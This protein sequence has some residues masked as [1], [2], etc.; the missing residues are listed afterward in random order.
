MPPTIRRHPARPPDELDAVGRLTV[1]A[2]VGAWRHPARRAVP[3]VPRRRR[4]PRR[5]GRA[6]GGGRRGRG[7]VGTVTF[8]EPGSALCEIARDGEAEIRSLAVAPAASGEGIGEALTRHAVAA[9]TRAGPAARGAVVVD[10]D[11]R[12]AP[13]LR[14]AG[15]H[16]AARARL[17]AGAA[18]PAGRVHPPP[19]ASTTRGGCAGGCQG[20]QFST[21]TRVRSRGAGPRTSSHPA[22]STPRRG[23]RGPGPRRRRCSGRA[24]SSRSPAC[25]SRRHG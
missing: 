3:D 24:R 22:G 25:G 17:V 10:V 23:H 7:V 8:V 21:P 18:R 19:L 20:N 15:L 12:R 16:P 4:A 6:V 2:Y 13:A 5:R 11:A 14:A 1:D 9:G